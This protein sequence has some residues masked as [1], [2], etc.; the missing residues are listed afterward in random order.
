MTNGQK[1]EPKIHYE[2]HYCTKMEL[3]RQWVMS[4][5]VKFNYLVCAWEMYV[6]RLT[7][8]LIYLNMKG[9]NR[10]T[11]QSADPRIH[12]YICLLT[13]KMAGAKLNN[14]GKWYH[15]VPGSRKEKKKSHLFGAAAA[16]WV[17]RWTGSKRRA[18][19]VWTFATAAV[20]GSHPRE[21]NEK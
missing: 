1:I 20:A 17:E 7:S 3:C 21:N 13:A 16:R 11:N 10:A 4:A 8:T 6:G 2:H 19:G 14:F 18:A 5:T 15:T 12:A 9:T